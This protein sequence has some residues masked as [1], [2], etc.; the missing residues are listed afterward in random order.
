MDEK[1]IFPSLSTDLDRRPTKP[2][3]ESSGEEP[4][5]KLS[6]QT[7][8]QLDKSPGELGIRT[9]AG[10][11]EREPEPF[12]P[13]YRGKSVREVLDRMLPNL[14]VEDLEK[15]MTG[16]VTGNIDPRRIAERAYQKIVEQMGHSRLRSRVTDFEALAKKLMNEA[17]N[18]LEAAS[19]SGDIAH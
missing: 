14:V 11:R 3:I 6:D 7:D 18:E 9:P 16:R 8:R 15:F 5:W 4:E 1:L 10:Y 17:A 12:V 13:R 19:Q 2:E